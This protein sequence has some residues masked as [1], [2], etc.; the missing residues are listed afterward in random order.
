[1]LYTE[2]Y[3]TECATV[4][5]GDESGPKNKR[6]DAVQT[7]SRSCLQQKAPRGSVDVCAQQYARTAGRDHRKDPLATLELIAYYYG[8][9]IPLTMWAVAVSLDVSR[10]SD[11]ASR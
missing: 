9:L 6:D 5:S 4:N 7:S 8:Y 11:I 2:Q 3:R 1:M 10:G